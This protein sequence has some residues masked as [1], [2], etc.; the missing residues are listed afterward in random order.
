MFTV[1]LLYD[2]DNDSVT[3]TNSKNVTNKRN[4]T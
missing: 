1:S 3:T 2:D 4:I